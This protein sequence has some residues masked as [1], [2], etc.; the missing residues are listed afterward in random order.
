[1]LQGSQ[2]LLYLMARVKLLVLCEQLTCSHFNLVKL[3]HFVCITGASQI[4]LP[5]ISSGIFVDCGF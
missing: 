4:D 5:V 2:F 3:R 1:M